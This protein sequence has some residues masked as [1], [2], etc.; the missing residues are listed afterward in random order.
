MTNEILWEHL[1]DIVNVIKSGSIKNKNGETATISMQERQL[2][3]TLN[4]QQYIYDLDATF[5]QII[6]DGWIFIEE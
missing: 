5:N 6:E 2:I 4:S 1:E 3:I